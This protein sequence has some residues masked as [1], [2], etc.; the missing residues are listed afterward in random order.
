MA[1][2]QNTPPGTVPKSELEV[3]NL[4][5]REDEALY[6]IRAGRRV[7][8]L[9]IVP[10]E[11]DPIYDDDTLSQPALL[12]PELPPF[13]DSDWTRMRVLR[14]PAGDVDAV[15]SY[16]PLDRVQVSW[17][18]RHIDVLSLRRISRFKQRVQEVEFEGRNAFAKV[19]LFEGYI[20]S[21]EL[22][23]T[24]Y[25]RINQHQDPDAP[26]IAPAFLGHLT[27]QGRIIGFLL[28]KVD[29]DYASPADLPKCQAAL[30][31]LHAMGMVHGD[32]NRYNFVVERPTG[33]VKM[34]DFEH[35]DRYDDGRGWSS[36]TW[37]RN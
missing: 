23:T 27:E 31:S 21:M 10:G 7:H 36:M 34:I 24:V 4:T 30:R 29:G 8:Y 11:F 3:L 33:D 6:R 35:A 25:D 28:E 20:P 19:A 18:P 16:E 22:E 37:R 9:E 17:H 26:S 2:T 13:P 15:V 32:P 5:I 1:S 14:G 12:I